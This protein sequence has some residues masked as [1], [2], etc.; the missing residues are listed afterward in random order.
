MG[1]RAFDLRSVDRGARSLLASGWPAKE[2][3]QRAIAAESSASSRARA[4]L[5]S[6]N[7]ARAVVM[8]S[9]AFEFAKERQ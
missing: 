6:L 7:R 4:R 8:A 9:D 2:L 3:E 5:V 1:A